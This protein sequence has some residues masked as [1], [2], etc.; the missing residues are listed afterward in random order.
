MTRTLRIFWMIAD[1][2]VF[3]VSNFIMNILFA[4]WLPVADY[5]MFAV[6]FSAYLFLTLI[7]W[8]A[9]LE[10]LLVLSAQ[11]KPDER[12]SYIKTLGLAHVLMVMIATVIS[13]AGFAIALICRNGDVGWAIIGT[14]VSGSL[15]LTLLTARR[16]CLVFVSPRMSAAIGLIYFAG[17]LATGSIL[18]K[19][20]L[21]WFS[22]WE[23][24]GSWACICACMI[25][26]LLRRHTRGDAPYPLSKLFAFQRRYA[27]G[28]IVA[29]LCEWACFDGIYV[30]LTGMV[31]LTA[32][33]ESKAVFN[34]A[35]PLTHIN[36]AMHA[37]WLVLFS[38]QRGDTKIVNIT[39]LY[40]ITIV[41]CVLGLSFVAQPLVG[42][43][44]AGRYLNVAWQLPIFV[45]AIGLSGLAAMV[46]S[47]FKARGGLWQGFTP[48]VCGATTAIIAG[49]LMIKSFGQ[50]GAVYAICIGTI[51]TLVSTVLIF[52]LGFPEDRREI[53]P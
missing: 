28:A 36:A 4:R 52:C 53:S 50:P 23:I 17:V 10:P 19:F 6:S 31:G 21:S 11:I 42:T 40:I 8:G 34:L 39:W 24:L 1:Q 9:F 33:A 44:Y 27:P 35:N 48:Q 5:G 30:M 26:A 18:A 7:H 12:R 37:S 20:D 13:L 16:L 49:Y 41:V 45:A 2:G 43:L 32:V 51:I 15:M 25:F 38:E 22:L 29:A 14:G 46:T 47:L 3:A